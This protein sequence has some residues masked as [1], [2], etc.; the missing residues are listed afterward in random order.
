LF[1]ILIDSSKVAAESLI[2]L[3]SLK[4]TFEI[5]GAEA[6]KVVALDYLKEHCGA[7]EDML[8]KYLQ[9]LALFINIDQ[10]I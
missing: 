2:S 8:G 5:A 6:V 10:D 4:E 7:I 9:K 3:K 1:Q